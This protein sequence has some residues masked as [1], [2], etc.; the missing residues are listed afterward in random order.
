MNRSTEYAGFLPRLAA[1]I[2]DTLILLPASGLLVDTVGPFYEA[3][4][5][6]IIAGA[7]YTLFVAGTWQATPGKRLM[8][9]YVIRK[10]GQSLDPRQALCRYLGY[11]M[12]SLPIYSSLEPGTAQGLVV[13]L[14]AMWFVPIILTEQKTG[15]HDLLC[16]TRVVKGRPDEAMNG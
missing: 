3:L 6:V 15:L 10:D 14:S 9:V 2:I 11:L 4:L 5:G 16:E 12:P 13:W 8:G 7:Y 1:V